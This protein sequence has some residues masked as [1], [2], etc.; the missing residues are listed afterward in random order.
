V[1]EHAVAEEVAPGIGE[2]P[3]RGARTAVLSGRGVPSR[4]QRRISSCMAA[5]IFSIGT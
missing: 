1:V 4:S 2:E 3:E 5:S